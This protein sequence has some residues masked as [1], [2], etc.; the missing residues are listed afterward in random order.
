[1]S[2]LGKAG[3]YDLSAEDDATV[4]ALAE[5]LDEAAVRRVAHWLAAA[6]AR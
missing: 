2:G 3:L 4:Q 6:G 1:M 5:R